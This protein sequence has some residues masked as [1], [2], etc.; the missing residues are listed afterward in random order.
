[1]TSKSKSRKSR[2]PEEYV[3]QYIVEPLETAF[4]LL[5]WS[6][7]PIYVNN[8]VRLRTHMDQRSALAHAVLNAI[9]IPYREGELYGQE[10]SQVE[11]VHMFR[12][13]LAIM[14]LEKVPDTDK[15]YVELIGKGAWLQ[16]IST[17]VEVLKSQ[18]ENPTIE[19]TSVMIEHVSN[20]LNKDIYIIDSETQ[21]VV[22]LSGD[23]ELMCQK[24]SSIV[25]LRM[26]KHYELLAIRTSSGDY[27]SHFSPDHPWIETLYDRL[28]ERV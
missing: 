4:E 3:P 28:A 10:I 2:E 23:L 9:Y 13:E 26:R 11:L 18:L 15:L 12:R 8:L 27:I 20:V 21:D 16:M 17:D 1:M 22:L 14:L 24:R 25:L 19:F 5:K 7:S 6:S